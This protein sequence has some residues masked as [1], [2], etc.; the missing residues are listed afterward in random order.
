MGALGLLI[1]VAL[2]VIAIAA[3]L[4]APF[5]PAEQHPGL[6]LRPPGAPYLLGTD[7]FGRDVLSRIIYGSQLSLLVGVVA[8]ALGAGV[9]TPVGFLAGYF[10]GWLDTLLMRICDALLAMPGILMAIAVIA[11]LGAGTVQ[12]AVAVAVV[13]VPEFARLA[14]G[15][16]LAE[17]GHEY[18]QAAVSIGCPPQQVMVRHLLPNCAGPLFVQLSLAMGFAVLASAALSFLG[19]GTGPPAPS[20]GGMLHDSRQYLRQAPWFGVFPGIALA[21]LLLGLSYLSDALRDAFDPTS[22]TS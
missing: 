15:S 2:V 20:W 6:E 16:V 17:R 14:R 11:V 10:G 19:L 22:R 9:G 3:P 5:D 12:T 4:I 1:L 21:I 7:D 18:V 8:V 13:S